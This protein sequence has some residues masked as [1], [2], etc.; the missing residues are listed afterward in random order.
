MEQNQVS[1][2]FLWSFLEQ[3]SVIIIQFVVQ[4]VLARLLAPEIFGVLAIILVVVNI[5]NVLAQSG[6]GSALIQDND[7]DEQAF[8][9]AVWLSL[10]FAALLYLLVYFLSGPIALFYGMVDLD[11]YIRVL[12]LCIFFNAFNSIQRS[13]LQKTMNFRSL[14]LMNLFALIASGIVGIVMAYSGAGIWALIAQT[15]VQSAIACLVMAI[16][17]PLKISFTFSIHKAK[18]LFSYGW[19]MCMTGVLATAYNSVSELIIGKTC[20]SGDLGLY[21]QGRKWPIAAIGAI[22]NA[23]ANVLFPAL[24][25]LKEDR[26]AFQNAII[27][28]LQSGTYIIAPLCFLLAVIAEPLIV[29]FL[30]DKWIS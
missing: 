22:T 1:K 9:T 3:A 4:I 17:T 5:L 11:L 27:R 20:T 13:Y 25:R 7:A 30:T 8:S 15:I 28:A 12:S 23:V 2:S 26:A 19:K 10:G 14:F 21:S 16:L 18:S 24:A 6:L 29:I